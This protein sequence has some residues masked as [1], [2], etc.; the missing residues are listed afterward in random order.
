MVFKLTGGGFN[1]IPL[2]KAASVMVT[3]TPTWKPA[4]S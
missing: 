2:D 3:T 1:D 4:D